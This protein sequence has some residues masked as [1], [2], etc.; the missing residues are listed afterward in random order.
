MSRKVDVMSDGSIVISTELN[1]DDFI[2]GLK[3]LATLA[4]KAVDN[5]IGIFT[6]LTRRVAEHLLTSAESLATAAIVWLEGL[7]VAA[8]NIGQQAF[9]TLGQFIS[10]VSSTLVGRAQE[11]LTSALNFFQGLQTAATQIATSCMV[12]LS[13]L[14]STI[15]KTVINSA[16]EMLT[17][18]LVF[19]GGIVTAIGSVTGQVL[20]GLGTLIGQAIER[21]KNGYSGMVEAGKNLAAGIWD[22]ISSMASTLYQNI[23]SL[24][25]GLVS[26]AKQF[27]LNGIGGIGAF[28][29][30]RLENSGLS[31]PTN[32]FQGS[33]PSPT[34]NQGLNLLPMT[35]RLSSANNVT[36]GVTNVNHYNT[37]Y[38]FQSVTGSVADQLRT[39]RA[40]EQV[41]RLRGVV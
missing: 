3:G 19:F 37:T 39:A 20:S 40:K 25:S 30:G 21:V 1:T 4:R 22:G 36:K 14:I 41:N 24:V 35:G 31:V 16:S 2:A 15:V 29:S 8:S 18:A 34:I 17:S 10:N 6:E 28:I 7:G 9:Q 32:F 12:A 11:L 26:S 38:Q 33:S 13:N 27:V 23:T 5:V